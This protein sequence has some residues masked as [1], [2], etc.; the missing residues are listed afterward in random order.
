MIDWREIRALVRH[1]G[2]ERWG[3]FLVPADSSYDDLWWSFVEGDSSCGCNLRRAF[4]REDGRLGM[5][6]YGEDHECSEDF[7]VIAW[8]WGGRLWKRQ[9]DGEF[10][11]T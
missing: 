2:R 11:T 3:R 5:D 6:E 10:R 4:D 8:E 9:R 7:E 1:D